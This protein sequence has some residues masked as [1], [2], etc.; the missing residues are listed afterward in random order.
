LA[1]HVG[2]AEDETSRLSHWHIPE[3]HYL[4]VVGRCAFA[5]DGTV[6]IQQPLI[7]PLYSGKSLLG[8]GCRSFCGPLVRA[9]ALDI[10]QDYWKN[11]LGQPR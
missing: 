11:R 7:E 1:V 4:E 3:A 5:F 2:A 9:R 6:S 8:S 10:V